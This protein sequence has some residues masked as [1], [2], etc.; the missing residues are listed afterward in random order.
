MI[1]NKISLPPPPP[2][3]F[4]ILLSW[5]FLALSKSWF[6]SQHWLESFFGS[7][8]LCIQSMV[9][10]N[11]LFFVS[12]S[13]GLKF[14][15]WTLENANKDFLHELSPKR[16]KNQRC[17]KFVCFETWINFGCYLTGCWLKDDGKKSKIC[18]IFNFKNQLG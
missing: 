1:A 5:K 17:H 16:L 14:H 9:L 2:S 13:E 3:T 8:L 12:Q 7:K 11:L 18:H 4:D 10:W 15:I 6:Y